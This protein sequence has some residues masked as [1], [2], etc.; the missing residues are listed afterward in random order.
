M[1]TYP[2]VRQSFAWLTALSLALSL[3]LS[4]F[5]SSPAVAAT[6]RA[7]PK[8]AAPARNKKKTEPKDEP[9]PRADS[10]P[11]SDAGDD[12]EVEEINP[13]SDAA[14]PSSPLNDPTEP[15]KSAD[16]A[17]DAR[18]Q[19]PAVPVTV[20]TPSPTPAAASD[21]PPTDSAA[22]RDA[23]RLASGRSEVGVYVGAGAGGRFFKYSDPIGRLLAPY[24]LAVAP[25]AAFELEAYPLASTNL[26][27]L[28]DIGFRGRV[29]RAFGLDSKTPDGATIDTSWTRF[30]GDVRYRII[31]PGPHRLELGILAGIAATHFAMST[32]SKLAALVPS[33][34]TTSVR[35]GIDGEI[36]ATSR[37]AIALGGGYLIPTSR[38]E[39]YD[40]FRNPHVAGIDAKLGFA[41]AL[42]PGLSLRL[43][44]DYTRYF[45]RFSPQVGDAAVAGGAL[46]QQWQAALG[47][48]Y[49]H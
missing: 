36:A 33:A 24:T 25:L 28:R 42:E 19:D 15:A 32:E 49:A 47:V 10:A 41:L 8:H 20:E 6:K 14:A 12:D 4:L 44:G 46:D 27:A 39:I 30:G 26:P 38:G 37:F 5:A 40:R 29:T 16:A 3:S 35:L 13:P 11:A 1:R 34:R 18:T 17:D 48:R 22:R 7:K 45:S 43:D 2:Q 21:A 23:L 9:A 31:V